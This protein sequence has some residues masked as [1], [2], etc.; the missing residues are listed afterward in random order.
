MSRNDE[1]LALRRA[2]RRKLN[3]LNDVCAKHIKCAESSYLRITPHEEE[4][5]PICLVWAGE[6]GALFDFIRMLGGRILRRPRNG[7]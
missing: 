4:A 7:W 6:R 2:V 5:C 3:D 1:R